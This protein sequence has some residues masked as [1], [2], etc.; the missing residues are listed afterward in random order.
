[1]NTCVA[2]QVNEVARPRDPRDEGLHKR[3][4]AVDTREGEHGAMVIEIGMDIEQ[5]RARGERFADRCDRRDIPTFGYVR[6]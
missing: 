5:A 3:V 2:A 4:V 6:D 1:M